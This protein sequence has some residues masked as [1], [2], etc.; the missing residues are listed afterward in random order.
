MA[1]E[2][3]G[4]LTQALGELPGGIGAERYMADFA[5]G[6]ERFAVNVEMRVWK[7]EDFGRL[8]QLADQVEHGGVAESASV[9][10]RKTG[11]SAEMVFKLAGDGAFDAPVSGIVDARGHFVGEEIAVA[12]EEFDGE[13]ADVIEGFEDAMGGGFGFVLEGVG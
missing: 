7:G 5:A 8:G 11:D 1:L 2:E 13:D 12:I 10:E 3:G 6:T 4:K 9:A